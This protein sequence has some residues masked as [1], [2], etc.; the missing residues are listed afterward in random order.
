VLASCGATIEVHTACPK[1][2]A[3]DERGRWILHLGTRPGESEALERGA[4]LQRR[5][6]E[7]RP[8]AAVPR[9]LASGTFEGLA[10]HCERRLTGWPADRRAISSADAARWLDQAASFLAGLRVPGAEPLGARDIAACCSAWR[11]LA[12][13]HLRSS[14]AAT[15]VERLTAEALAQLAQEVLPSVLVHGDLR[16]RHLLVDAR[17]DV[18][19][20]IHW[21]LGERAGPPGLDCIHLHLHLEA[22]RRREPLGGPL[23]RLLAAGQRELSE[24]AALWRYA[25]DLDLSK[26]ALLAIARLHPLYLASIAGRFGQKPPSGW[27]AAQLGPLAGSS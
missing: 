11:E 20:W 24:H 16:P 21:S 1:L 12:R 3:Q 6:L 8:Q 9:P 14:A 27:L 13:E 10:L 17:S 15:T 18:R 19:G 5:L 7:L 25:R 26:S 4:E 22:M 2:D 23:Q